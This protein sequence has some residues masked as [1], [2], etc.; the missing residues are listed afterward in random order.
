M[1]SIGSG[2]SLPSSSQR[3]SQLSGMTT[4]EISS[5]ESA[6]SDPELEAKALATLRSV[7]RNVGSQWTTSKQKEGVLAVLKC[8]RDVLAIM[9]T[10]S[11]KTMLIIIPV[12]M[13]PDKVTVVMLP[14]SS[15][16]DD[17]RR[18]L[19][20][21]T[22]PYEVFNNRRLQGKANLILV[23]ADAATTNAWKQEISILNERMRVVRLI[24][25]EGHIPLT[26]QHYRPALRK[27]DGLREAFPVQLVALSGSITKA[28]EPAVLHMF[29]LGS[30]TL[31]IRTKTNRPELKFVWLP[32][33][34]HLDL[35]DKVGSILAEQDFQ[36]PDS[37][38][39][40]FVPSKQIGEEISQQLGLDFYCGGLSEE[41]RQASHGRWIS[42]D[43]HRVMVCTSAFGAGNDYPHTRLVVHAGSP[44]EMVEYIQEVSRAGRD[45][46]PATCILIPTPRG[47]PS[48]SVSDKDFG[49]KVAMHAALKQ[50]NGCIRYSLTQHLDTVGTRCLNAPQNQLCSF[51]AT[52]EFNFTRRQPPAMVGNGGKVTRPASDSLSDGGRQIPGL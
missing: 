26:A 40:I 4:P 42:G 15:L 28:Q 41:E 35:I 8:E 24:F 6:L 38:A 20:Q 3:S 7:L 21:Y 23:S 39:L 19:D 32:E 12:L 2:F 5:L 22:I 14:L 27:V 37:R 11:G 29:C 25:D 18:R 50:R 36:D 51:C 48:L 10:G 13:Q 17:L 9:A 44:Y 52:L 33:V 1:T 46:Q 31:T 16:M 45:K 30:D 34:G 43:T 49:G 47:A